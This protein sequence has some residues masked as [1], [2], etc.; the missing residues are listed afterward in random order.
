M[1]EF[2]RNLNT[3]VIHNTDLGC[4]SNSNFKVIVILIVI[5][6]TDFEGISNTDF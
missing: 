2:Q 4:N 1:K 6:Y 5:Y 3:I